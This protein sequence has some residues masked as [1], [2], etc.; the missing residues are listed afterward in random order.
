MQLNNNNNYEKYQLFN[1]SLFSSVARNSPRWLVI[2][3]SIFAVYVAVTVVLG[4]TP[5][6]DAAPGKIAFNRFLSGS[7]GSEM[8]VMD[9]D[10]TN[11]TQLTSGLGSRGR[12]GQRAARS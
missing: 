6:I 10:G 3:I 1:P 8:F 2:A 11:Q 7:E 9:P 5:T 4:I 12:H